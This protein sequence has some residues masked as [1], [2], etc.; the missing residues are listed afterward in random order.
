VSKN[1]PLVNSGRGG[2]GGRGGN[3]APRWSVPDADNN[4]GA[5]LV[6]LYFKSAPVAGAINATFSATDANDSLVSSASV[7]SSGINASL[8]LTDSNDALT[9]AA[10]VGISAALNATDQ[11]DTASGLASVRVSASSA[12]TDQNDSVTGLAAALASATLSITDQNDTVAGA[13]SARIATNLV[14]NDGND[15]ASSL[16]SVVYAGVSAAL[17]VTDENDSI[18]SLVSVSNSSLSNEVVLNKRV[19]IRRGKKLLIFNSVQDADNYI[20]LEQTIEAQAKQKT[21][22]SARRRARKKIAVFPQE[23]FEQYDIPQIREI[24]AQYAVPVDFPAIIAS[25]DWERLERIYFEALRKQ[26]DEDEE[27]LLLASHY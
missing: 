15:T 1:F 17:Q 4:R 14:V 20:A 13:A 2:R 10:T 16:V 11:N 18:A 27:L 5:L 24:A 25:Q 3:R 7:S 26:D 19:Y 23:R 21:S 12:I 22:S 8:S 6:D 9:A